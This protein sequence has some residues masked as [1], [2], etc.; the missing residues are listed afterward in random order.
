MSSGLL[1]SVWEI[2]VDPYLQARRARHIQGSIAIAKFER[3]VGTLPPKSLPP[4]SSTGQTD[5]EVDVEFSRGARGRPQFQLTVKATL[6]AECQRCLGEVSYCI[7]S[8]KTML[9]LNDE[10]ALE[11]ASKKFGEEFEFVLVKEEKLIL[12][13]IIEDEL[14]LSLPIMFKHDDCQMALKPIDD[15]GKFEEYVNPFA[16]L[17][18]LKE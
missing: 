4:I 8:R 10:A 1:K 9:V 12:M 14:L 2:A 17:S 3:L 16:V 5:I 15:E 18:Q 13:P 11:N 6:F 7:D